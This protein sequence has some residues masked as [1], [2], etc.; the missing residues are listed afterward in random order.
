M[1]SQSLA[2][3]SKN[4]FTSLVSMI[5]SLPSALGGTFAAYPSPLRLAEDDRDDGPRRERERPH[6]AYGPG[7]AQSI[8]Y[9]PGRE[10][11]H[12]VAKVPPEA[13]D[14]QRA[15]PPGGVGVVRD[16]GDEGRVDHRRPQPQEQAAEQ[17]PPEA[18]AR[19]G[20]EDPGGLD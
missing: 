17:P 7:D 9:D 1:V 16:G 6:G 20:D 8:G 2:T 14:A 11:A 3:R 19:H 18:T 4:S 13:I 15:R 5:H 12:G 10:G